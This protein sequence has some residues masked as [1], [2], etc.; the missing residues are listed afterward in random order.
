MVDGNVDGKLNGGKAN[1]DVKHEQNKKR[2]EED[3]VQVKV[4][5]LSTEDED[6]IVAKAADIGSL[7]AL[8]AQ[9]YKPPCPEPSRPMSHWDHMLSEVTWMAN[10]VA[11]ER[12]WKATVAYA[13]AVEIARKEGKFG[14]KQPPEGC[15]KY[16]D[17]IAQLKL[18]KAKELGQTTGRR[19]KALPP[20]STQLEIDTED[21]PG[22]RELVDG[23]SELKID[24]P[25]NISDF[26]FTVQWDR[27]LEESMKNQIKTLENKRTIAE[28]VQYRSHRLEYEAALAS[29]QMAIAEQQAAENALDEYELGQTLDLDIL[30]D[31]LLGPPRKQM[32]R[33]R[34]HGMYGTMDDYADERK[35]ALYHDRRRQKSYREAD[36]DPTYSTDT[37]R[38]GTRRVAQGRRRLDRSRSA[39]PGVRPEYQQQNRM[40]G[41]PGSL[42]WNRSEDELLLAVV[43]EFGL[44]WTLVS[45]VLSR[46]LSMHG[47]YR[48]AQQCRQ[49]F[50]QLMVRLELNF[51]FLVF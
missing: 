24:V 1:G 4:E 18:E 15:R 27:M 26:D 28:E 19:S 20:P 11:Q 44:N 21:D 49:R 10:D 37:G 3:G 6:G 43:H 14:L 8:V 23:A 33:A 17:E 35:E 22:L 32:K 41:Q 36:F 42:V 31:G 13:I 30:D 5:E 7:R 38:Y 50:R 51:R 16:S 25:E 45:E 29:H 40:H 46:S 2:M 9:A 47:I 39:R 48:P 34:G 12:L